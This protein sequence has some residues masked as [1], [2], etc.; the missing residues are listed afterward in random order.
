MLYILEHYTVN[1]REGGDSKEYHV[2]TS[3]MNLRD[4]LTEAL[5]NLEDH[6]KHQMWYD[7]AQTEEEYQERVERWEGRDGEDE[8]GL[9]ELL[10][11][12]QGDGYGSDNLNYYTLIKKEPPVILRGS[13]SEYDA[14]SFEAEGMSLKESAKVGFG[15]GAGLL[16]FRIVAL[17]GAVALGALLSRR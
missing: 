16:G 10:M 7:D 15:L 5:D 12:V 2:G 13:T 8:N 11:E 1:W 14:E 4:S 17:T 3:L 9:L 6:D